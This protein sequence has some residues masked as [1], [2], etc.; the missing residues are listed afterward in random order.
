MSTKAFMRTC[1]A[2]IYGFVHFFGI[3]FLVYIFINNIVQ[4]LQTYLYHKPGEVFFAGNLVIIPE[5]FLMIGVTTLIA[6][7]VLEIVE[8][9]FPSFFK[10]ILSAESKYGFNSTEVK[11]IVKK[12]TRFIIIIIPFS[13]LFLFIAINE[14]ISLGSNYIVASSASIMPN[15]KEY[16]Y[17][18]ITIYKELQ[19]NGT[20]SSWR[21]GYRFPENKRTLGGGVGNDFKLIKMIQNKQRG[22]G[23]KVSEIEVWTPKVKPKAFMSI[24]SLLIFGSTYFFIARFF[25]KMRKTK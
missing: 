25:T 2:I 24:L 7:P 21:Y 19:Q 12:L 17:S 8:K 20:N 15:R 16:S 9:I 14:Y 4:T 10:Y 11:K 5:L 1:V 13:L 18:D 22:L 23:L 3:A 6:F